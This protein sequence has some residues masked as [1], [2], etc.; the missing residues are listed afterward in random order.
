[1]K[2]PQFTEPQQRRVETTL[3]LVDKAVQRV[4]FLL[5]RAVRH[6]GPSGVTSSLD[7]QTVRR[8]RERFRQLQDAAA[9]LYRGYGFHGRRLDLERVLDAELSSLWEMLEDCRPER[10]RG[11]GPME[12]QTARQLEADIQPLLDIV[13]RASAELLAFSK[14]RRKR[15]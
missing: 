7:E 9:E 12:E 10:M 15:E 11:F 13:N 14:A 1:M 4:E 6:H 3:M 2:K 5:D 8:L